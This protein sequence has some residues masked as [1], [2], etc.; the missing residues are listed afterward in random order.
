MR[1]ELIWSGIAVTVAVALCFVPLLNV[2]GYEFSEVFCCLM[3]VGAAW[4]AL[5]RLNDGTVALGRDPIGATFLALFRRACLP[6][7]L[8]L[9]IILLNAL[10]VKNCDPAAGLTLYLL[11]PVSSVA[12]TVSICMAISAAVSRPL[13]RTLAYVALIFLSVVSAAT[14]LALQPAVYAYHPTIGFFAGSIYDE[15]LSLP[16]GLLPFR[17]MCLAFVVAILAGL[18][19]GTRR[20]RSQGGLASPVV[21]LLL[22]LTTWGLVYDQRFE[23]QIESDR[24]AIIEALGGVV[25]SEHFVIYYSL[26]DRGV[27][28]NID[29]VVADHEFRYAQLAD[30]FGVEPKLPLRV[31]LYGSPEQKQRYMGAGRTMIAKPWLQEIH[32]VYPGIGG[33]LLTHELAHLFS[34]PIGS[35]PLSL[36][37]GGLFRIDMGL[38][39]GLAEAAAWDGG[40]LTFHGWSA[41]IV[42]LDLA[43]D[44]RGIIGAGGFWTS[45]NRQAYTLMG[46]FCRWLIDN[47]G[48]E[49]FRDL[50]ATGDFEA[51]FDDSLHT[52]VDAWERFLESLPLT[53]D[54]LEV[55][56][57]RFQRPSIFGKT[58]AHA[59]ADLAR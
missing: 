57:F 22:A 36:A 54:Q 30:F 44:L 23:L 49:R 46:S 12:V 31:F 47:Q 2:L 26:S 37:G 50:Y 15:A 51:A 13:F 35:G 40:E 29:A 48:I 16:E 32:L 21:A 24:G 59:L 55:A 17:L 25:E 20:K 10:R 58:C 7:L 33:G 11:L 39:E 14:H 42:R 52:L 56:R 6:L 9:A 27:A 38:I 5:R 43:P 34:E 8:P 1:L 53:D 18:E 41:A 45:Y 4:I 28:E 19:I 3:T